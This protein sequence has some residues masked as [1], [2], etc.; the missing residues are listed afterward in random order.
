MRE[1]RRPDPIGIPRRERARRCPRAYSRRVRERETNDP[2]RA[3][4]P[5]A[6]ELIPRH[7]VCQ[8]RLLKFTPPV[9]F[10]HRQR[11][12]FFGPSLDDASL[13][14]RMSD[15]FETTPCLYSKLNQD[16]NVTSYAVPTNSIKKRPAA[17]Q[18]TDR[19]FLAVFSQR[20]VT[21]LHRLSR[22]KPCS[23]GE[24]AD[25]ILGAS[26]HV[27]DDAAHTRI[28]FARMPLDFGDDPARFRS[29]SCLI[30]EICV[31]TPHLV[32]R[33]PH[34]RV[35]RWPTLSCRRRLAGNRIAYLTPSASRYS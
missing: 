11:S 20:S 16:A 24:R 8:V 3:I 28:E 6:I 26:R 33:P 17:K 5:A 10:D 27:G 15:M 18:T 22:R 31:G 7:F 25:D 30:G 9:G 14:R 32:R 34:G 1:R 29:A 4:P 35:S 2:D 19:K 21:R 13:L 23:M 12:S